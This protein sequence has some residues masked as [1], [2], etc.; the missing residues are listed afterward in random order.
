MWSLLDPGPRPREYGMKKC[1]SPKSTRPR[2][3]QNKKR[4]DGPHLHAG[5]GST[6]GHCA[7]DPTQPP[8]PRVGV[9]TEFSCFFKGGVAMSTTTN[10]RC[11][12]CLEMMDLT[13]KQPK[14]CKCGYE[15]CLWCWHRIMN[16][17]Q[18]DEYGGRCPGCRLKELCADKENY[19]KEQTK[20]H[21]QTS[22]KS[23]LVQTEP[24]DP[25]NVRVI[26]RKLVYI[27]GMPNEFASEKVN[28][29]H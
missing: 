24:K 25:N 8:G 5:G 6:R 2:Q 14:P 13:D 1:A 28:V 23:Q 29:L 17:D 18:K 4:P 9:R 22:A 10:E 20:S 15:I 7:L 19:Q 21:K 11:P 26:Q 12:L 27:V 3:R 16:M